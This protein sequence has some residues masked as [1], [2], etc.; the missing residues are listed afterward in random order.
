LFRLVSLEVLDG[1]VFGLPLIILST[2]GLL[3]VVAMYVRRRPR[4]GGAL[5]GNLIGG[6]VALLA[7]PAGVFLLLWGVGRGQYQTLRTLSPALD[8][9]VPVAI[10]GALVLLAI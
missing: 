3:G 9:L 5:A 10:I 1:L 7:V 8:P 2:V 6:V 4:S